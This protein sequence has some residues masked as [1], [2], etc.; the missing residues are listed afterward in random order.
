MSEKR[1]TA[2]RDQLAK[3]YGKEITE[4]NSKEA[5]N[6]ALTMSQGTA[7]AG[8]VQAVPLT[9]PIE[10]FVSPEFIPSKYARRTCGTCR[11]N[12]LL[13]IHVPKKPQPSAEG[14]V[15]FNPPIP[16]R[17]IVPKDNNTM[18]T[19]CGCASK[20]YIAACKQARADFEKNK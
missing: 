18:T 10:E 2:A 16:S 12:G 17:K 6:L 8:D 20:R 4:E 14:T 3:M 5:A 13:R 7:L 11:G 1:G 9:P 19:V 15:G